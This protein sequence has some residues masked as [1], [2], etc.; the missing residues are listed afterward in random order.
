MKRD[1]S[2]LPTVLLSAITLWLGAIHCWTGRFSMNPDG[3]S[4]LDVGTSFF[5]HDWANAVNAWWSPL[6][7]WTIGVVLGVFDPSPRWEFPLVHVVN[8][9][10]FTIA[11]VAFEAFLREL[12]DLQRTFSTTDS[13]DSSSVP[14]WPLRCCGYAIFWWIALEVET[15]YDVAPDLAVA[16]CFFAICALLLRLSEKDRPWKFVLFGLLLGIGYWTKAVLFPLGFVVLAA[17]YW[18]KRSQPNWR[19]GIVIAACAFLLTCSP[20]IFLLSRQKGRFTFGDSG[21]GNYAWSMFPE[22]QRRNWQGLEPGS[23]TPVH[24]TRQLMEHPPVYEFDGPVGGTYPP[25]TDPSYWNEGLHARFRLKSEL[26]VLLVNIPSEIRLLTRGQPGLLVGVIA[27]ALL[28]GYSW[29]TNLRRIWPLAVLSLIGMALYVPLVENDRYLGGFV[30]VLFLL[31]LWAGQFGTSN[32][33]AAVGILLAVFVSMALGTAD[34]TVR[35]LTG[36]YAIP[37]VEPNPRWQDV[38]AA[39]ELWSMGLQ[40]GDKVAIVGDG[41]GAYWA[42]LAKLR[43]V[44]EIMEAKHATRDFWNSPPETQSQVYTAFRHAHATKVIATCSSSCPA[45]AAAGWQ[46]IPGTPYWIRSLP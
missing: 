14:D 15:V 21:R 9:A 12:L 30:A 29:W 33:K 31:L 45:E 46:T 3:M 42:R 20:L 6:Y 5:R 44:A 38:V 40:P 28:G 39:Q 18:W 35:V 10:I 16:A 34:Y 22:I 32:K 7:P 13:S 23:G 4:Y 41:S 25:R 11:M 2:V 36:H 19:R 24:P 27:L 37:G 17:A 26:R 43:I 1:S 8:F